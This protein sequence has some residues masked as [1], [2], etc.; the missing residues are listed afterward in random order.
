[1]SEHDEIDDILKDLLGDGASSPEKQHT[2]PDRHRPAGRRRTGVGPAN[3]RVI[4]DADRDGYGTDPRAAERMRARR[5]ASALRGDSY[6]SDGYVVNGRYVDRPERKRPRVNPEYL[7]P[8][9]SGDDASSFGRSDRVDMSP[10]DAAISLSRSA[11]D[12]AQRVF[13]SFDD[14]F[15]GVEKTSADFGQMVD[16]DSIASRARQRLREN[17]EDAKNFVFNKAKYTDDPSRTSGFS[18]KTDL[19][20]HSSD[21]SPRI[22]WDDDHLPQKQP[23]KPVDP[24]P[25]PAILAKLRTMKDE[26][27]ADVERTKREAEALSMRRETPEEEK[28]EEPPADDTPGSVRPTVPEIPRGTSPVFFPIDS[29]EEQNRLIND[30]KAVAASAPLTRRSEERA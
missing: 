8:A 4:F 10:D 21:A 30:R 12:S 18:V 3:E 1:M 7:D 22:M 6:G 19:D 5:D 26:I 28:P 29:I 15:E 11:E 17:G 25:E 23:S 2:D 14:E 27:N 24:A 20:D 13:N 9:Y 16:V